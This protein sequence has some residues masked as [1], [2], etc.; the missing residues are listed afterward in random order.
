M[1][2]SR[3]IKPGLYKNEDLAE[4]SIWARYLFPGL[5]TI[6]DRE[7]RLED[8]PKRIKAELLPFD[9]QDVEPLLRELSDRGFV[10]RYRIDGVSYLQISKFSKHQTPHYTE[11][12][13]L[14]KPPPLQEKTSHISPE[15][16]RSDK[17]IKRGPLPP[18]S[19]IH[20]FTDSPNHDSLIPDSPIPEEKQSQNL[21]GGPVGAPA[22][23]ARRANGEEKPEAPTA[24]TWTAYS[25]AYLRRHGADPVRNK[26]VNGQLANLVSKLGKDSAPVAAFYL[27]SNRG[28]YVSAKHPVNL[29]LRDA[30][31][32]H[33]EWVTGRQG[34][35]TEARQ[36]DRTAATGNVFGKLIAEAEATEKAA[37]Q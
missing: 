5:W 30:E 4:C 32:L 9:T 12:P 18:N 21:S 35:E 33:T 19:L 22:K 20:R 25:E 15:D 16:S 7:G 24:E 13:S 23:K 26:V 29:L 1:A 3:N 28:L 11:K 34:T 37:A 27:T 2:R 14:I 10:V 36:A 17:A 8:R 31:T 6:A